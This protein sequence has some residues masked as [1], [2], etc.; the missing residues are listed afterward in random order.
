MAYWQNGEQP[1][2][3][4]QCKKNDKHTGNIPINYIWKCKMMHSTRVQEE[5]L[6][7]VLLQSQDE[8]PSEDVGHAS[9]GL[10]VL[11]PS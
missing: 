10:D 9:H 7:R 11:F 5:L 6:Y 3:A 2:V 8:D 1:L 4:S